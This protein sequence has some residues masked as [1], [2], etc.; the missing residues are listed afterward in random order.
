MA[1][2]PR[3]A[4]VAIGAVL[5]HLIFELV[6]R[7]VISDSDVAAMMQR[8]ADG[9]RA[10]GTAADVNAAAYIEDVI[11]PSRRRRVPK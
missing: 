9:Q 8:A 4:I 7:G 11:I 2:E 6:E 5:H 1:A 3:E 10:L